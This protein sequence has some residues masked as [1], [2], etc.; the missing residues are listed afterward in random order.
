MKGNNF[1]EFGCSYLAEWISKD[2][3]LTK[4]NISRNQIEEDGAF[5]LFNAL[6]SNSTLL[7]LKACSL[8]AFQFSRKLNDDFFAIKKILGCLKKNCTLKELNL[9][10]N[11]LGVVGAKKLSSY[12]KENT[13]L[14]T[15]VLDSVD[16][17]PTAIICI[18]EALKVNSTLT[19]LSINF[20]DISD[21]AKQ[22]LIEALRVNNSLLV[23][24]KSFSSRSID[25]LIQA[26]NKCTKLYKK[27]KLTMAVLHKS[28][29]N[30]VATLPKY[31]LRH[32]L[33]FLKAEKNWREIRL[34]GGK[35][36]SKL[37]ST[38]ADIEQIHV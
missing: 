25:S 9:S 5:L 29:G 13:S 19:S 22:H 27:A 12:L 6:K 7:S 8:N 28:K 35:Y 23:L 20:N 30:L 24:K 15:L 3:S 17:D 38:L 4:L 21:E 2:K 16:M 31:V 32:I 33:S 18:S 34:S 26:N 37:T 10:R 11:K 36:T 14:K 1:D